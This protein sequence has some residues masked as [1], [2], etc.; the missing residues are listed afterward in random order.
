MT[1]FLM[2]MVLGVSSEESRS[3]ECEVQ[4]ILSCGKDDSPPICFLGCQK[5]CGALSPHPTPLDHCDLGC[6]T[7]TCLKP[8]TGTHKNTS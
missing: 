6:I 2:L 8:Y 7:A 1:L 5:K 4:C 3:T